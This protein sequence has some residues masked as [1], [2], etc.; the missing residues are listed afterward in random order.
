MT[1]T[2]RAVKPERIAVINRLYLQK[3]N[4]IEILF[5]NDDIDLDRKEDEIHRVDRKTI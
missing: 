1:Q 2:L 3:D 5:R 4:V